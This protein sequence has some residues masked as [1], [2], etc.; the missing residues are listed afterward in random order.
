MCSHPLRIV[1]AVA[2]IISVVAQHHRRAGERNLANLALAR[3]AA[4]FSDHAHFVPGQCAAAAD[5][6]RKAAPFGPAL[7][8]RGAFDAQRSSARRQ[9]CGKHVLRQ[10]V[11]GKKG[12]RAKS[13]VFESVGESREGRRVNRLRATA[14]DAPPGKVES[15]ADR[16]P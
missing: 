13:D 14:G 11:A 2:S 3:F 15:L 5:N 4:V 6:R 7:E 12:R 9:R 10:A 16:R 8:S 1:S